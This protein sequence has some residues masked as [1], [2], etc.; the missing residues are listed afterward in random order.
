MRILVMGGTRFVGRAYV[1]TAIL[2]DGIGVSLEREAEL[3][4]AWHAR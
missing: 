1:E 3:L 2:R 4:A